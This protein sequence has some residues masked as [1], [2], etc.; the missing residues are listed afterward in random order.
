MSVFI[1]CRISASCT[2]V[3]GLLHALVS[4]SPSDFVPPSVTNENLDSSGDEVPVT[5]LKC[6]WVQPRKLKESN[7]KM[8]YAK[9]EKYVFSSTR[10]DSLVMR[11]IGIKKFM[12][13]STDWGIE[14][15]AIALEQ[16]IEHQKTSG[17]P[18]IYTCKS[19]FVISQP[20]PFLGAS[21]DGCVH[22][23][24]CSDPFGLVEIKCP[25][26]QRH[27]TPLVACGNKDFYCSLE[28]TTD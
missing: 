17:H 26:S 16:Y 4:L 21:P 14:K 28:T 10:P 19:G 6:Q 22:D 24:S 1:F 27:I 20:H 18:G 12:A 11:I 3:S 15:E 9:F 2:H 8:A 23:P 5:S 25:Y 7:T 13:K